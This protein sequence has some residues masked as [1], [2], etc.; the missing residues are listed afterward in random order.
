MTKAQAERIVRENPAVWLEIYCFRDTADVF[1][2][3]LKEIRFKKL[4]AGD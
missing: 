1:E 2:A 3:Q 4:L